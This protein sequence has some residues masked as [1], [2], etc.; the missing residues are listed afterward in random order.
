MNNIKQGEYISYSPIIYYEEDFRK[1]KDI[2]ILED[3]QL[4]IYIML[5]MPQGNV[6]IGKTT[7]IEQRLRSLSGS[8]GA[9]NKIIALYCSPAT[10]LYSM[11]NTC[12]NHYD[13]ARIP[14]TEWFRGDKV[15]FNEVVKYVD[16]LFHQKGYETCNNLRK[17]I[18]E[19]K[20]EK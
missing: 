8:N 15:N 3:G 16:G 6:K 5:S 10:Y 12:H 2:P 9:G 7:N 13:F 17:K 19:E 14:N 4:Y 20:K 11:E 18:I 1:L